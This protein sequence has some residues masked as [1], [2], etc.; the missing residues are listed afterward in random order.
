MT[1]NLLNVST[2]ALHQSLDISSY[3]RVIEPAMTNGKVKGSYMP[4]RIGLLDMPALLQP[5]GPPASTWRN[6]RLGE[7]SVGMHLQ[8]LQRPLRLSC[9]GVGANWY[10]D[11]T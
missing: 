9:R 11:C 1:E 8:I 6:A 2:R 10:P 5:L 3:K 7:I 4:V